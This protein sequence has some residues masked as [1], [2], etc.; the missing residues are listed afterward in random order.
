MGMEASSGGYKDAV[1]DFL[2]IILRIHNFLYFYWYKNSTFLHPSCNL[3][4]YLQVNHD[5]SISKSQI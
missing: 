4:I 5:Q 1:K 2:T 3:N